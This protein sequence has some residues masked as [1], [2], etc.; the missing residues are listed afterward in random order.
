[1]FHG[2]IAFGGYLQHSLTDKMIDG[3]I[4]ISDREVGCNRKLLRRQALS[5]T[6][7]EYS[8]L[9][10]GEPH[11]DTLLDSL[12]KRGNHNLLAERNLES[13]IFTA[14]GNHRFRAF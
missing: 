11:T 2:A 5:Q 10:V 6:I 8:G 13:F 7:N 14:I 3:R 4:D 12:L 9:N 1:M